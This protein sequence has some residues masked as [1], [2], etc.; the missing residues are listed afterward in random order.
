MASM[1]FLVVDDSITIRRIIT[2]TLKTI[3]Y[4]EVVE[5]ANGKEALDKLAAVA[6]DFIITDWNM[7]EMNGL[8]F[9][10]EVRNASATAELPILMITTRGTESDVIEALQAKVNSYIVK[11]FTP[12]ELKDKIDEIVK[13]TSVNAA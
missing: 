12:Q 10:K 5:A 8:D 13:V 4:S 9:T 6:I 11:P 1:K 7:P 2:N 3:G